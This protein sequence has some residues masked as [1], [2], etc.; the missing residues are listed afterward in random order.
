MKAFDTEALL[1][2]ELQI[3]EAIEKEMK[4]TIVQLKPPYVDF[5]SVFCFLEMQS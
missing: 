4:M 1:Y 2:S 3:Q 5:G